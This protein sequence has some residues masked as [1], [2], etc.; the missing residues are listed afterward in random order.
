MAES[1]VV[2]WLSDFEV[3]DSTQMKSFCV[4]NEE[5][6]EI[7]SA[8]FA[9]L[10]ER[11]RF[12]E[13]VYYYITRAPG[14]LPKQYKSYLFAVVLQDLQPILQLLQVGYHRAASV[15]PA[16]HANN[17]LQLPERGEPR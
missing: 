5:N 1:I 3:L 12:T 11:E 10:G 17:C 9:I 7:T 13:V 14:P 4:E 8:L 2:D 16:V 6:P 15:H